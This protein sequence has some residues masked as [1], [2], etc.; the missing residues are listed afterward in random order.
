MGREERSVWMEEVNR[1]KWRVMGELTCVLQF[2]AQCRRFFG[3]CFGVWICSFDMWFGVLRKSINIYSPL[4]RLINSP[5][6]FLSCAW[7]AMLIAWPLVQID[8]L[9]G[10]GVLAPKAGMLFGG[11][12]L[13][14]N[15]LD[16]MCDRLDC[17]SEREDP[18][19]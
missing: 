7:D 17:G 9:P 10:C 15:F 2:L 14:H 8:V 11:E 6:C 5:C 4:L 13:M 18:G 3:Q 16:F 1:V 12:N 19:P